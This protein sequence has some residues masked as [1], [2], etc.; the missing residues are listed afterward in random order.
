MAGLRRPSVIVVGVIVALLVVIVVA[1]AVIT[2]VV[3]GPTAPPTPTSSYTAAAL[4]PGED[5]IL[6]SYGWVDQKNGIARIPIDRAIDILAA[7]GLPARPTSTATNGEGEA[8]PS[9]SSS[10]T[11]PRKWLH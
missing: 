11:Q 7:R 3:Q 8:I 10:G 9:Y 5:A 6:N 4:R 2:G 1:A